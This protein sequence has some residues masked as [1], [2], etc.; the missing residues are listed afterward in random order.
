MLAAI[1]ALAGQLGRKQVIQQGTHKRE[2][3][4]QKRGCDS[5]H[6]VKGRLADGR[7]LLTCLAAALCRLRWAALY[8]GLKFSSAERPSDQ[9]L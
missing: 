4:R 5:L 6:E 1:G 8:V 7:C 9:Q 2:P 3:D